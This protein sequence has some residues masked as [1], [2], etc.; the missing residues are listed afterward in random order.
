MATNYPPLNEKLLDCV[1]KH[2]EEHPDEHNQNNWISL[3]EDTECGAVCCFAGWAC[4]LTLPE[5]VSYK[6]FYRDTGTGPWDGEPDSNHVRNK[7]RDLLGLT[8]S[9]AS[10]LFQVADLGRGSHLQQV[11]D[12]IAT[13]K[14]NRGLGDPK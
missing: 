12:R 14:R 7:A 6:K 9:E 5:S 8:D 10:F 1:L 2:I 13:I 3:R 11:K 4:L